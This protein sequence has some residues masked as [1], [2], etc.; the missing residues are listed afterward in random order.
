MKADAAAKTADIKAKID[1]RTRELDAKAAGGD[2]DLAEN[3]ALDALD[4]AEW[5]AYNAE[6]A[7]LDAIHARAYAD[8]LAGAARS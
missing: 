1:R 2:A 4:F 5:A 3:G 6:L 8:E 7:V